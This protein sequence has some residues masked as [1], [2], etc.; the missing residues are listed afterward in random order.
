MIM[1]IVQS[2]GGVVLNSQGKV[3]IVN[4]HHD[5][6]SLPKGHVEKGETPLEAAKREIYEET[7]LTDLTFV[8]TFDVYERHRI[9]KHGRGETTEVKVLHFFLFTTQAVGELK[10]ID[11]ENPEAKWIDKEEVCGFLSHPQDKEFFLKIKDSL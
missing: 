7:G 4:Q 11:P 3:A 1:R 8:K 6:W 2:A 5:S 9:G 10:P